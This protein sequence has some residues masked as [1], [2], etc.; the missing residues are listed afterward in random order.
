[1]WLWRVWFTFS[2]ELAEEKCQFMD[3]S[4]EKAKPGRQ[5]HP[6]QDVQKLSQDESGTTQDAMEAAVLMDKNL[7]QD[8]FNLHALGSAHADPHLCDFWESCFLDE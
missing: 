5:L 8:L 6:S 4:L 3:W 1:M 2:P 7:N